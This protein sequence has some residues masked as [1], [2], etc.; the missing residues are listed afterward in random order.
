[1]F[2]DAAALISKVLVLDDDEPHRDAI[3]SFCQDNGLVALKAQDDNALSVLRSNVDL[4]AILLWE[5]TASDRG[6]AIG[7]EI[8][9]IRPELPIFLRREHSATLDDLSDEDRR[10]FR[11]AYS[12]ERMDLLRDAIGAALFSRVYP[13]PLVRGITELT[14]QAIEGQ[15][16]NVH[17]EH[18]APC[19][20]KDRI[21]YGELFSLIPLESN[22]CRGYMMLQTEEQPLLEFMRR[23]AFGAG[24]DELGFREINGLLGEA[25]NLVWG[26]FKNRF[27]AEAPDSSRL[28]QVPIIVNHLHRYISFGSEDPQLCVKYRLTDAREPG[29]GEIIVYQWFAFN[30]AWTPDK[31]TEC[32]TSVE[33]LCAAG[34]LELF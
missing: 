2:N 6:L 30:L 19:L 4:G 1:M 18:E 29:S 11:A 25:T 21:I 12:I 15:F 22:W 8:H 14:K 23:E 16:R 26:A 31:F 5:R 34:E 13:T 33:A 9:R 28:T 27:I 7:R 3:K 24:M 10:C 20:V 17:V 32:V